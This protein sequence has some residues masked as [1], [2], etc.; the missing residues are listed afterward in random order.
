MKS[1]LLGEAAMLSPDL[2]RLHF[3]RRLAYFKL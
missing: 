1:S 3:L 2:P